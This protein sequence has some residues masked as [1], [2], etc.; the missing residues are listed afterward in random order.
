MKLELDDEIKHYYFLALCLIVWTARDTMLFS[1][2]IS[3]DVCYNWYGKKN[4]L[5]NEETW[6]KGYDL[7]I[8]NMLFQK[9]KQQQKF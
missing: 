7:R 9:E 2:S 4:S 8:M 3:N 6:K 1:K 5:F